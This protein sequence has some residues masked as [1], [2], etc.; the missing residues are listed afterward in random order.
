MGLFKSCIYLF[1][2]D[3]LFKI[4]CISDYVSSPKY[5]SSGEL[6]FSYHMGCIKFLIFFKDLMQYPFGKSTS[7]EDFF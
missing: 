6:I 4:S 3:K 2:R 1:Y 5:T 7:K